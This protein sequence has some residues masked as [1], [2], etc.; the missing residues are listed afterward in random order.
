MVENFIKEGSEKVRKEDIE[1]V[2]KNE[3]SIK[4]RFKELEGKIQKE[5]AEDLSLLLSL[6]KDY[7]KDE[8]KV[9]PWRTIALTVF[10]LLYL[11]NPLDL[12]PDFSLPLGI[13]DDLAVLGFV[14]ASVKD[15]LEKYKQWKNSSKNEKNEV[16]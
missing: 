6:I 12:I 16:T 3:E 10:A 14:V 8:Y 9:V 2:V 1:K 5:L 11:L 15:D 7:W 4:N 13:L